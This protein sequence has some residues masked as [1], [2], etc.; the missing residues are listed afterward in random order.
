MQIKCDSV[1]FGR[2]VSAFMKE[3]NALSPS[4]EQKF[5]TQDGGSKFL[6]SVS[7]YYQ[8][9]RRNVPEKSNRPVRYSE[10]RVYND[11]HYLLK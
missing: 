2:Y 8:I 11:S 6:R 9:K 4:Q 10:I 5:Y 1:K 7:T 3:K